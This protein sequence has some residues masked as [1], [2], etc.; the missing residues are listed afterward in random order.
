MHAGDAPR[1]RT[2]A[3][4]AG[5][6]AISQDTTRS[7][8]QRIDHLQ[9]PALAAAARQ[10]RGYVP[11]ASRAYRRDLSTRDAAQRRYPGSR[12]P[13]R[14][15]GSRRPSQ[16]RQAWAGAPRL[17]RRVPVCEAGVAPDDRS[18][19]GVRMSQRRAPS[20]WTT[21]QWV[22]L[23]GRRVSLD[24]HSW[25]QGPIAGPGGVG[26]RFFHDLAAERGLIL[27]ES[28]S[29]RGLLAS[30]DL[31]AGPTFDPARVHPGVRAFYE[32]TSEFELDA[33]A[34]WYGAFRPFGRILAA[35]FSRRLQQLNVP[36]DPL[37]TS[38][39]TTSE[40]VHLVDPITCQVALTAWVRQ[41]R[42]TGHVLYAGSYSACMV[43]GHADPCVK[44]DRKS[45]R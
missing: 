24:E 42:R 35:L 22:K 23:T 12:P 21:Q 43:P 29:P 28:G 1:S 2:P 18:L 41:R 33:W 44:V 8:P 5:G 16:D 31:L 10:S 17:S 7:N 14:L 13:F 36:L 3:C 20:D 6:P 9:R 25:L 19:T 15:R 27:R 4:R 40:V 34:E 38:H 45:T 30:L 11:P 26:P 37:D 32:Q 39:G